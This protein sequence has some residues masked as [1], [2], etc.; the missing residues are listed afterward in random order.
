MVLDS[1]GI[2]TVEAEVFLPGG[3]KARA[4]SPSGASVGKNEATEKRDKENYF[5]GKSV[6]RNIDYIN[7]DL[8]NAIVGMNVEDQKAID[9]KIIEIDGTKNKSFLGSNTTISISMA[10]LK[11]AAKSNKKPLW[12]YLAKKEIMLLPLPE[13]QIIGGGLHAKGSISIQDF[14]IIPN[15]APNFI[16]ALEWVYKVYNKAN[17]LLLEKG[18]FRGVADEGGFW[19][20]FNTNEQ[21]IEF[22]TESICKAG[23]KP[24]K[25]ISISLDLAANNFRVKEG[26]KLEFDTISGD[27]MLSKI[28]DWIKKYPIISIEDPFAEDDHSLFNQLKLKAPDYLQIVGDDLVVTNENLIKEASKKDC[29]NSL[30]I[31][32]NQIGTISETKK[33]HDLSNNLN[34][35]SI[36]S[37][38]SGETEDT[39]IAD[40]CVGWELKQIKVGSISRSERT[41]KWNQCIRI[42]EMINNNYLMH[43]INELKWSKL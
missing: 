6:L 7:N 14:L 34:L 1:R 3:V 2:P 5:L 17:E 21:I 35:I 19:P 16:T 43:N 41:S 22:V 9:E 29:I 26:Y 33:A 20:S 27:D 39:T 8:K 38:R 36:M 15:G 40:L 25:E 37:A 32:P 18:L 31:K 28:L 12:N 4:I 42:G 24:Y 11:A 30:L 10:V 23:F 13:I